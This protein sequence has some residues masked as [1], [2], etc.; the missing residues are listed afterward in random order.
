MFGI[1]G[2]APQKFVVWQS[3]LWKD[4]QEP[5]L[6][7]NFHVKICFGKDRYPT[8]VPDWLVVGLPA[9]QKSSLKVC[10]ANK[11]FFSY[12][13]LCLNGCMSDQGYIPLNLVFQFYPRIYWARY[14]PTEGIIKIKNFHWVHLPRSWDHWYSKGYNKHCWYKFIY[15]GWANI[16]VKWNSA[17]FQQI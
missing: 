15:T 1:D 8:F 13:I 3:Q 17:K 11:P 14:Q 4:I 9:N 16:T 12:E 5:V 6:R 10:H 7:R 2:N